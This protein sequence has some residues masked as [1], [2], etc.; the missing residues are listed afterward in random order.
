MRTHQLL[1][2][3]L[4]SGL[5]FS[6]FLTSC[7]QAPQ[8]SLR[9]SLR[10]P[11]S[12]SPQEFSD[13]E[14]GDQNRDRSVALL[15]YLDRSVFNEV[16]SS[17]GVQVSEPFMKSLSE[18]MAQPVFAQFVRQVFE[19]MYKVGGGVKE[20][21]DFNLPGHMI[22]DVVRTDRPIGDILR[23]A[24]CVDRTG[25]TIPCD[26]G[27]PYQ[28][29]ILNTR[30]VLATRPGAFNIGRAAE[31]MANL[32]CADVTQMNPSIQKP[33]PRESLVEYFRA[34]SDTEGG[35]FDNISSGRGSSCYLCH[36]YFA[37]FA[38]IFIKYD[39][40]G[41]YVAAADGQPAPDSLGTTP[42]GTFSSHLAKPTEA[43]REETVILNQPV[44]NMP[45]AARVISYHP[46]FHAC[47]MRH[48]AGGA[49]GY[50]NSVA[51]DFGHYERIVAATKFQ[52]PNDP[53]AQEL[54][55]AL[56]S[57]LQFQRALHALIQK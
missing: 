20:G 48:L 7:R 33:L 10:Q 30:A 44:K 11:A 24:N 53:T 40:Q 50:N 52:S 34:S 31:T 55:L 54:F 6:V 42:L 32:L 27:A 41:R 18:R 3:A 28:S 37:P 9:F 19:K 23:Q 15:R 12:T 45:D 35:Q 13:K 57:D 17:Q 14:K 36:G 56:V 46:R 29:G 8:E 49:F 5:L 2:R 39:H 26:S 25:R 4:W 21:I 43:S 16:G 22:E 47:V 1:C 38:Q 51:V